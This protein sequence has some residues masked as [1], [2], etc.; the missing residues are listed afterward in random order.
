MTYGKSV[1][2]IIYFSIKRLF[3]TVFL[4]INVTKI[5]VPI[6]ELIRRHYHHHHHH[7]LLKD[8]PLLAS[9]VPK[10]ILASASRSSNISPSVWLVKP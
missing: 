4:P 6:V 3:G 2:D 9:S 8:G 10:T 5:V 1:F 7:H